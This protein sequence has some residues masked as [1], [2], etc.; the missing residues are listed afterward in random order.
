MSQV[1]GRRSLHLDPNVT[2]R[3]RRKFMA[4]VNDK[5]S[6][7]RTVSLAKCKREGRPIVVLTAYDALTAVWADAAGVDVILV[8]DSLG[9]T[10]LGL[11][12]T[13]P[14]TLDM[15]VH[16]CAAVARAATRPLLVGDLP[17]MTYK[18]SPEQALA[19]AGRLIQE[20]AMEAV[21][22]EG[23]AEIA[24]TVARLVAAGIPV[25]G[26]I[27]LLPQSVHQLGGYRR[28]G[29]ETAAAF[30]LKNDA[31]ALQDAGA[32]AVVLEL[33]PPDLARTI[34]ASLTIP[35][36]GIG[37][38]PDCD[39]QV[40]VISD[41]L[42]MS[43]R[44][45]PTF[46]RAYADFRRAAADAITRYAADVRGGRFPERAKPVPA[47]RRKRGGASLAGKDKD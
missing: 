35:T 28:Q 33:I 25:M 46:V 34:T 40:L 10:A 26:H 22:L 45:A 36:I 41:V 14:V 17:F 19:A 16:H 37:A 29:T 1:A 20:G 30:R 47:N 9:N 2:A 39:G 11:R 43:D 21:K 6:K 24:P 7:F 31:E 4:K 27:G 18:A 5:S 13:I 42:G 32:F 44:P 12:D 38:G 3:H 23:G 8:G 15:M